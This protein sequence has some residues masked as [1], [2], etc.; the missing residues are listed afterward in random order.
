MNIQQLQTELKAL[1]GIEIQIP[2]LQIKVQKAFPSSQ[3]DWGNLELSPEEIDALACRILDKPNL[4]PADIQA[5]K[6]QV[7]SN[8]PALSPSSSIVSTDPAGALA[9]ELREGID[10]ALFSQVVPAAHY[11]N[12]RLPDFFGQ[13]FSKAKSLQESTE[14]L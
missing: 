6:A 9:P 12:S 7:K 2:Q 5:I 11:L 10:E 13:V 1:F 4:S 14:A 8:G 3:F